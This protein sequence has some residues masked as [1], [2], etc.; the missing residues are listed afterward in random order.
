MPLR[1]ALSIVAV[2]LAAAVPALGPPAAAIAGPESL[3]DTKLMVTWY[4]NPHTGKMGILGRETGA[5]RAAA[6]RRQADA[7]APFTSKA[8]LPAYHLVAVIAQPSAGRDGMYR[9]RESDGVIHAMLA[10]ARVHGFALVLDIQ[11]GRS[12]VRQEVEALRGFLMEPDVH[13]ALDPEFD[14]SASTV[15]GRVIGSMEAGDVNAALDILESVRA[16]CGLPPKVLIVHQFTLA[17]LPDKHKIRGRAGIDLVLNMDGFGSQALKRD[18]Y[19]AVF[20][21]HAL[22]FAGVKL[23]YRQDVNLFDPQQ[24]M[25]LAPLPSVIIYQ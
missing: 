16:E 18:S 1:V 22:P 11:P 23:F 14:M 17:M 15:P 13:L 12:T 20:R 9:R 2:L 5:A 4:G 25:Q 7:Y 3:L 10:E 6:L 19:R 21:Q 24:V 8:I